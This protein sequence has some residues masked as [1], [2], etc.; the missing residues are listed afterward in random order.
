MET[1]KVGGFPNLRKPRV[2]FIGFN[3]N[4]EMKSM[5]EDLDDKLYDLGFEKDK[6]EFV[7]HATIGRVKR[8]FNIDKNYP[9]INKFYFEVS[10]I[11]L[12]KSELTRK[13]SVYTQLST[14]VL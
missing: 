1:I 2:I 7:P 13:G 10:K 9:E 5:K 14:F 12:I 6:R 4:L 3:Q 8:K 11:A